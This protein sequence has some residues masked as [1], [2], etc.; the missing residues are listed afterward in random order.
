MGHW[1]HRVVRKV[2][3]CGSSYLGIHEAYY[4]DNGKVWSITTDPT[5]A[6]VEEKD[7]FLPDLPGETVEDLKKVLQRMLEACDKPVLDADSIPEDGASRYFNEEEVEDWPEIDEEDADEEI[8][9]D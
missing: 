3:S 4:D 2:L 7:S 9:E 8:E 5:D 1:N 6:Q